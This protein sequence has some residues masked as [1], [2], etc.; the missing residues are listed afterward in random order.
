MNINMTENFFPKISLKKSEDM[1]INMTKE[2][3]LN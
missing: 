1:N 3:L 2:F